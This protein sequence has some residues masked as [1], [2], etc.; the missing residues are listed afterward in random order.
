M[1]NSTFATA[2]DASNYSDDDDEVSLEAEE[3]S[4]ISVASSN[5]SNNDDNGSD[6]DNDD[7]DDNNGD[8]DE[9]TEEAVF[10][11][12]ARDIQNR[13]SQSVGTAAME[14][15][16]FRSLFGVRIKIVQKVWLLLWEDGL[17]PKESKSNHLLWTLY[18][19]KVYPREAPSCS[20]VGGSKGAIN[21]KTLWKWV[22]LFIERIA[23]LADDVRMMW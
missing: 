3:V 10:L 22:W 12:D 6:D 23:E 4:D 20:A 2:I 1:S 13:T 5:D 7:N 8:N 9:G 14:D 18:F 16:W 11:H 21:P 19:L 17:C 15:R